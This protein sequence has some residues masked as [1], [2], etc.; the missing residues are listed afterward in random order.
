[1]PIVFPTPERHLMSGP[2]E[3]RPR[4]S[5]GQAVG[6]AARRRHRGCVA[7]ETDGWRY[8]VIFTGEVEGRNVIR[9][10]SI[11]RFLSVDDS[12]FQALDAVG[13]SPLDG[14]QDIVMTLRWER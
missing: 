4:R 9:G 1:M 7:H 11:V 2:G 6:W 10:R 8:E 13:I 3:V 5:R 14:A 12:T